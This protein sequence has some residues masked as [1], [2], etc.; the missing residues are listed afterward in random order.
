LPNP[1]SEY[2][3]ALEH[4]SLVAS[5]NNLATT[6]VKMGRL[7][8][9]STPYQRAIAVCRDTLGEDHLDYAIVLKN[10]AVVLRKLGRKCEAMKIES[11][12]REIQR[13]INRRNGVGSTISLTA[14]RSDTPVTL[15]PQ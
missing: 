9:A 11:Q 2:R 14:L 12:G 6:Y 3:R 7:K 13:A 15:H 1:K 4:P 5:L 8:D 10:Y